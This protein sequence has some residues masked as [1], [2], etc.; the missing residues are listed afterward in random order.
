MSALEH[1]RRPL[2]AEEHYHIYNRSIGYARLY[3]KA[4]NY[5]YFKEKM[6]KYSNGYW[7]TYAY[8][9][10]PDHFHVLIKVMPRHAILEQAQQANTKVSRQFLS[11]LFLKGH[12]KLDINAMFEI[13]DL[14]KEEEI[15]RELCHWIISEQWRKLFLSYSKAINR[16]QE[17][18]GS[19]FQKPFRRKLIEAGD[20]KNLIQYIHRNPVHHGYTERA[21]DYPWSSYSSLLHEQS[22]AFNDVNAV[23]SLYEGQTDF[24]ALHDLYVNDWISLNPFEI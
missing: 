13:D 9:L 11:R 12:K 6:R 2:L 24:V 18:H 15:E 1:M 16:Q 14:P 19:L 8:A 5:L 20:L 4:E 22:E 10:L 3:F 21:E 23:L 7:K 17:R